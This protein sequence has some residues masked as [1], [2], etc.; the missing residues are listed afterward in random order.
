MLMSLPPRQQADLDRIEHVL[1]SADPGLKSMFAAFHRS[2]KAQDMPKR[3]VISGF[4]PRRIV[5][6]AIV[7]ACLLGG[8]VLGI[9][10]PGPNCPNAAARYVGCSQDAATQS[11]GAR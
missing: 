9:R 10:T 1:Q 6:L 4:T 7:V 2:V 11:N 3:E 8:F 5:M